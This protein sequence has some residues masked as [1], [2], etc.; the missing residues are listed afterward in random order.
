MKYL[1]LLF[2]FLGLSAD[3]DYSFRVAY[4]TASTKDFGEILLFNI[5]KHSDDLTVL[6]LDGGYLLKKDLFD[7][8]LD[9]YLKGGLSYFKEANKHIYKPGPYSASTYYIAPR[10]DVYEGTIYAKA[11]YNIDFW[12]NRVRAGIGMGFSY[13]SS[14]LWAEE[15]EAVRENEKY[16]KLLNYLDFSVDVDLGK[17]I[18]YAP[19]EDTYIGWT[20]KHRS[21]VFGLF[22]GV[23][24]GSN[25]NTIS[26]ERNF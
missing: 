1:V 16:A 17:L 6:S 10:S 3:D 22:D 14:V 18:K 19:L 4:G 21:G 15:D 12:K 13:T 7:V 5:D 26:I 25:Y 11:Y 20:I 23:N 2:L 24:G 9:I 8:P